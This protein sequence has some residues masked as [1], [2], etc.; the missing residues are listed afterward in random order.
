MR[1]RIC[2]TMIFGRLVALIVKFLDVKN[3]KLK[4][5][6]FEEFN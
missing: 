2:L 6:E 1:A 3:L 5:E 4:Y